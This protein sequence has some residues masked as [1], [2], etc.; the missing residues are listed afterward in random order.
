MRITL[1]F[2]LFAVT[3]QAQQ[4]VCRVVD[5]SNCQLYL[6]FE[7]AGEDRISGSATT[8]TNSTIKAWTAGGGLFPTAGIGGYVLASNKVVLAGRPAATMMLWRNNYQLFAGAAVW[9][10]VGNTGGNGFGMYPTQNGTAST[11]SGLAGG[12]ALLSPTPSVP[13][14]EGKLQHYCITFDG[15]NKYEF[16]VDGKYGSATT[17][18]KYNEPSG[19][20]FLSA[21]GNFN[22]IDDVKV[23]NKKLSPQAIASQ[24]YSRR[25]NYSQ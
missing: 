8:F 7:D 9:L 17:A 11:F 3:A 21:G 13:M 16:Y 12:V 14:T 25:R 15:V 22:A 19:S 6:P 23:Y 1:A 20:T 5:L 4:V 10:Y 2:L 24:V 18:S